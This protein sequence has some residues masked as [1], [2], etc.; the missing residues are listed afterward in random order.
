MY[1]PMRQT[2]DYAAMKLVVRTALPPAS[3]AAVFERHC[4]PSIPIS[5]SPIFK[6]FRGW[7]TKRCRHD[8]F[9]SCC[10]LDLRGLLCCL[11]RSGF[12]R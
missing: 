9:W 10:C 12:T 3:L 5:R 4:G 8:A 7:L 6:R 2:Q 11:H 1:L